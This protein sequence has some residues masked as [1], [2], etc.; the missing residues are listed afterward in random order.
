MT[1]L[2]PAV[3]RQAN[4]PAIGAWRAQE[5]GGARLACTAAVRCGRTPDTAQKIAI[6]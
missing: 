2:Y 6:R 5:E 4:H 1:I 3:A